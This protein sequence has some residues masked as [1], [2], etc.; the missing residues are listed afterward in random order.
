MTPWTDADLT[1]LKRLKLEG[2]SHAAITKKL[3]RT[4]TAVDR[5]VDRLEKVKGQVVS[6]DL[7][8]PEPSFGY[9]PLRVINGGDWITLGLVADTHLACRES[10][11]DALHAQYDLFASEGITTVLHA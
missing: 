11:L 5:Q 4:K 8:L 1:E 6:Q 3:K 9:L 10:R 2:V 7:D